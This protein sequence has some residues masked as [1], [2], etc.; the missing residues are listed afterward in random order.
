[1]LCKMIL[2]LASMI[3][4]MDTCMHEDIANKTYKGRFIGDN[5]LDFKKKKKNYWVHFSSFA[6]E[7]LIQSCIPSF[8]VRYFVSSLCFRKRSHVSYGFLCPMLLFSWAHLFIKK[9]QIKRLLLG[10]KIWHMNPYEY[11]ILRYT[12][13]SHIDSFC[14]PF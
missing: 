12:L 13:N 3:K 9:N 4:Q 6:P 7:E 11:W 1:M 2:Y 14:F 10:V 8:H 5:L